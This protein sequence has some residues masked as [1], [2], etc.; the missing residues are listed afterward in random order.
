MKKGEKI[1]LQELPRSNNKR[2]RRRLMM[3]LM[4]DCYVFLI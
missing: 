3:E 1:S 4:T 2:R